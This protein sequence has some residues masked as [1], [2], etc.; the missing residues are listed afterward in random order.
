MLKVQKSFSAV[1]SN[2]QQSTWSD[3]T[4]FEE[5]P[6]LPDQSQ[7]AA[8]AVNYDR[9]RR[10]CFLAF[11]VVELCHEQTLNS[12]LHSSAINLV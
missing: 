11:S 9:R 12:S 6:S 5:F 8:Y 7:R 10:Q 3:L 2:R 4:L 1:P